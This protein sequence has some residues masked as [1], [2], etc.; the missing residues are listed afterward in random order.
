MS[1]ESRNKHML[2]D[3][4]CSVE[5]YVKAV[6]LVNKSYHHI[7]PCTVVFILGLVTECLHI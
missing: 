5:R 3:A 2:H 1:S 4:L 6:E 7:T